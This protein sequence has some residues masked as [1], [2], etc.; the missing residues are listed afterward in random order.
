MVIPFADMHAGSF[1][2][3]S[4]ENNSALIRL[5]KDHPALDLYLE[6]RWRILGMIPA[7]G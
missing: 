7:P 4:H 1:F 5:V 6:A 3:L 2:P